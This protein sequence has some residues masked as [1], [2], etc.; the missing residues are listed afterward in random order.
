MRNTASFTKCSASVPVLVARRASCASCS[1]V[2]CTSMPVK[3]RL[4]RKLRSPHA[5]RWSG[6]GNPRKLSR[7]QPNSCEGLWAAGAALRTKKEVVPSEPISSL[8]LHRHA[9]HR[10]LHQEALSVSPFRSPEADFSAPGSM[11]PGTPQSLSSTEPVFRNGLSLAR[12]GCSLSEASIPGSKVPA[13]Y[14][15]TPPTRFPA[16]SAFGSPASAG[17]PQSRAASSL[18]ARCVSTRRL[19]RLLP[20]SPLPSGIF[21]SLGIEAFNRFRCLAARLPNPPDFLSLPAAF[22]F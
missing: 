2:N 12:N 9:R 18:Q 17:L 14:F 4:Q 7:R 22:Y 16:R 6:P 21:A 15:K 5:G 8:A 19:A 20:L 1:G 10:A 3:I 13:C 11:P